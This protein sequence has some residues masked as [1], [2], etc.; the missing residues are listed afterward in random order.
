MNADSQPCDLKDFPRRFLLGHDVLGFEVEH[1]VQLFAPL[2]RRISGE[3]FSFPAAGDVDL[4]GLAR[5][6]RRAT[7]RCNI[8]IELVPLSSLAGFPTEHQY[9]MTADVW[10]HCSRAVGYSLWEIIRPSC[11]LPGGGFGGVL[12][13]AVSRGEEQTIKDFLSKTLIQGLES[14]V[15][16]G[17]TKIGIEMKA[18][19]VFIITQVVLMTSSAYIGLVLLQKMREAE[20]LAI[21]I[22]AFGHGW[23]PLGFHKERTTTAL[24]LVA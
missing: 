1:V 20:D 7:E 11:L 10:S 2:V 23:I 9:W 21:L 13:Q 22:E 18:D 19:L 4:V 24:A 6:I 14:S 16:G 8:S 15:R 12:G 5:A 17:L 3:A